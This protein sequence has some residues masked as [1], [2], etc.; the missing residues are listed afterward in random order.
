MIEWKRRLDDNLGLTTIVSLSKLVKASALLWE[1]KPWT[2]HA[3]C[4]AP[5]TAVHRWLAN[6]CAL[7]KDRVGDGIQEQIYE[8]KGNAVRPA[9]HYDRHARLITWSGNYFCC[10]ETGSKFVHNFSYFASHATS[11]LTWVSISGTLFPIS[12]S[13]IRTSIHRL[14]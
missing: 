5:I 14:M 8:M 6:W 9:K 12:Y 3:S 7:I 10:S 1:M 11:G 4:N 2:L 13:R